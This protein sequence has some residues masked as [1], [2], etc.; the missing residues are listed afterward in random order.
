M[1]A[2]IQAALALLTLFQVKHM[3]ADYFLQTSAMLINRS[4]YAHPGRA[5]HAAIHAGLSVI[6]L[7][8]VSAPLAFLIVLCLIEGIVHYHIDWIKGR[9]SDRSGD[10]PADASY[11]R[12]FG[13]D[14]LMHQLTYVVM[15]WAW[16]VYAT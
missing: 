13:T 8:I 4:V 9:Y 2:E 10:T 6:C 7:L 12:A 5:L 1:S 3:F 14:Q 15:L 11:W 16:A